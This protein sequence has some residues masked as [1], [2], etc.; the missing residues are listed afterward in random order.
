MD[1]FEIWGLVLVIIWIIIGL[2]KLRVYLIDGME[3]MEYDPFEA[4][5]DHSRFV[6]REM[7]NEYQAEIKDLCVL[8]VDAYQEL[9]NYNPDLELLEKIEDK[10]KYWEPIDV[11]ETEEETNEN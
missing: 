1:L 10:L 9:G 4:E 6:I 2:W 3:E 7:M 11:T 8:L 5:T